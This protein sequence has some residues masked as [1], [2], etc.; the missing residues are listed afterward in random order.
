MICR[1]CGSE[2]VRRVVDLGRQP[3]A[4]HFPPA[5]GPVDDPRWPLELWF[6]LSCSLVQLGPIE[7]LLPEPPLA[8][9]SA[10][11]RAHAERSVRRLLREHPELACATVAEFASHHGGS[12]LPALVAAGCREAAP[13][14]RA[15]LVVD[16][17][18]MA[19]EPDVAGSLARRAERLAPRGC[20]LLE[21]HHLLPLVAGRQFDTVRHG[22]W[23]Y[24]S[25]RALR[26][27][28]TPL[29]LGV[30]SATEVPVFGGS[31]QVTL[32]PGRPVA[33]EP[34]G[35]ILHAELAAGLDDPGRLAQLEADAYRSADALHDYLLD[36]RSRGRTVLG[37]GAPSKAPVLLGLS[38]VGP[39]L[40]PFT[41]DA[42]PGKHGRRIP[43][44]AVP[45]RPVEELRA[46]RPDVVLILTWDIA[47]EVIGQLEA[48]GGWGAEYVVPIPVPRAVPL[49]G[50][51]AVAGNAG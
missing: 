44:V 40:L 26:R 28:A 11:S 29:G 27:L 41:V 15:E 10:T 34:L 50:R 37:Y 47:D 20:L 8:V 9:E 25:L 13:G 1:G 33:A 4:D 51:P 6:C 5:A 46:L 21:F 17:H 2:L 22:H 31:L 19:H 49:P 18:A 32:R 3:A 14:E 42:A 36:Q 16:V 48:G 23:S 39:E 35:R 24:F 12:W 30:A 7:P 45:I 38:R 43:G